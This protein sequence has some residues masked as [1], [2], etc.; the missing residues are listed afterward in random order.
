MAKT[1]RITD[2]ECFDPENLGSLRA[3]DCYEAFSTWLWF[4]L[5]VPV[6][7]PFA[8]CFKRS[9]EGERI[10]DRNQHVTPARPGDEVASTKEF[11]NDV[12]L[13]RACGELGIADPLLFRTPYHRLLDVREQLDFFPHRFQEGATDGCGVGLGGVNFTR[14]E[15]FR[16]HLPSWVQDELALSGIDGGAGVV[17]L[18]IMSVIE[19]AA[20]SIA[21]RLWA[22]GSY[23]DRSGVWRPDLHLGQ[24]NLNVVLW[25]L[26]RWAHPARAQYLQ[27]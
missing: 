9:L 27:R 20:H 1:K 11:C 26:R 14:R 5:V 12:E 19:K 22:D 7:M 6:L 24:D 16:V 3:L 2:K 8:A 13:L 21:V 23:V 17:R 15:Y 18:H 25:E 4:C 10:E